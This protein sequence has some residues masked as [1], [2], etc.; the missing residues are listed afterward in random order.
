MEELRDR[1]NKIV[2]AARTG[3]TGSASSTLIAFTRA[4]QIGIE[5]RIFSD[6]ILSNLLSA[7]EMVTILQPAGDWVGIADIFEF[8]IMKMVLD[9]V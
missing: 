4:V 8:E 3:D 5:Q 2:S 1:V 7:I 9:I 6:S